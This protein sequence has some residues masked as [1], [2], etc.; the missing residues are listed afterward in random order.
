MQALQPLLERL[1]KRGL[2]SFATF[3]K[4]YQ[5][6][7]WR[8]FVSYGMDI[9][10]FY[11]I[12]LLTNVKS[13]TQYLNTIICF[14]KKL[15]YFTKIF[16]V[17]LIYWVIYMFLISKNYL[18]HNKW[19]CELLQEVVHSLAS[20]LIQRSLQATKGLSREAAVSQFSL[21]WL[22]RVVPMETREANNN[23]GEIIEW[24]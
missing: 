23:N 19:D 14:N 4:K 24:V 8:V 18:H 22:W 1:L 2:E 15:M 10:I 3:A 12:L 5:T 7:W 11:Q 16:W 6:A 9:T 13:W 17:H 21:L 20:T